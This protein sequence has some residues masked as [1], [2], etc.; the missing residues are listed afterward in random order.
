MYYTNTESCMLRS[1]DNQMQFRKLLVVF[2]YYSF[3]LL[4]Y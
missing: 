2:L 3:Y 4:D 1:V